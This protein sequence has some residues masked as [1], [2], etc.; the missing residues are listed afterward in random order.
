MKRREGRKM[1]KSNEQEKK[2]NRECIVQ[3][4][5]TMGASAVMHNAFTAPLRFCFLF[6]GGGGVQ[7]AQRSAALTLS[8]P[9]HTQT[10][11]QR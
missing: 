4:K 1:V 9:F 8:A 6:W 11:M 3:T 5:Q 10:H 7:F 2:R